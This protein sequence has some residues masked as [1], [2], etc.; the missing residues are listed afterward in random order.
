MTNGVFFSRRRQTGV[1][2]DVE[3]GFGLGARQNYGKPKGCEGQTKSCFNVLLPK[4]CLIP[5]SLGRI[6]TV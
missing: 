6:D 2:G 1:G 4:I 5:R 3:F